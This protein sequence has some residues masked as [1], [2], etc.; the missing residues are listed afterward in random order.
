MIG[1]ILD[2]APGP[3]SLWPYIAQDC[4]FDTQRY[5]PFFLPPLSLPIIYGY[6]EVTERKNSL[7]TSFR[8]MCG[9]IPD[10]F[11]N[12]AKYGNDVWAGNFMMNVENE[13]WPIL[14]LYS[15]KDNLMAY[16]YVNKV[17]QV[18][19]KQNKNRPV[20][21]HNFVTSGHVDHMRSHPEDYRKM[22]KQFLVTNCK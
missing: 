2:S 10:F 1:G 21:S 11:R 20:I 16:S 9:I 18:K 22:V 3:V 7:Y 4:G 19:R 17:I 13:E 8:K 15:T 6:F 14:F 12:H 5:T